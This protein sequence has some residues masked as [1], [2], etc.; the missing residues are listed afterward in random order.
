MVT[1]SRIRRRSLRPTRAPPPPGRSTRDGARSCVGRGFRH[2]TARTVPPAV[3]PRHSCTARQAA[4]T[5]REPA[6][7]LVTWPGDPRAQLS[8]SRPAAP[9][10][11]WTRSHRTWR[12]PGGGPALHRTAVGRRSPPSR[13]DPLPP[14]LGGPGRT[15][16]RPI[17]SYAYAGSATT[18]ASTPCGPPAGGARATCAGGT[19]RTGASCAR[20]TLE[21]AAAAIGEV[22]EEQRCDLFLRQLDPEWAPAPSSPPPAPDDLFSGS[23]AS[24]YKA[25]WPHLFEPAV[26]DPV[27]DFL[28]DLAGA[29][30][31]ALELGIG[32]GRIA[33]LLGAPEAS[34]VHGIELSPAMVA[35]AACPG[36]TPMRHRRDRRRLRHGTLWRPDA[37]SLFRLPRPLNTISN[38]T[39]QDEQ[40]TCFRTVADHLGARRLLRDRALHPGPAA[41][42]T[43]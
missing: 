17:E 36:P 3:R 41:T 14:G 39:T 12:P 11:S 9:R 13:A 7:P 32:T 43:R 10:P 23:I 30:D 2:N 24:G 42:P 38:L 21:R 31:A 27:V 19:S 18:G 6:R 15:G 20:S 35:V 34:S 25:K 5:F 16:R 40:V 26:V 8:R 29:G 28:A 1:E 4:S 33:L 22:D 37:F